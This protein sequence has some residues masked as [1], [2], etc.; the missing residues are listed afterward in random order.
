MCVR[1]TLTRVIFA[2]CGARRISYP[3][4]PAGVQYTLCYPGPVGAAPARAGA[5]ANL[6]GE[7]V[8]SQ[9]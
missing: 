7:A 8:A 6:V 2:A 1:C 9:I 5:R 3:E 4:S